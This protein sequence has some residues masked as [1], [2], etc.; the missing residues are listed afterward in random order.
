MELFGFTRVVEIIKSGCVE[1]IREKL[2]KEKGIE[3][4]LLSCKYWTKTERL[5]L[6]SWL[7]GELKEAK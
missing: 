3:E 5:V 4:E 6:T 2:L 1:E 7:K